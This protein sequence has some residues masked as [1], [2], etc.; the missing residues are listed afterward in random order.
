[1]H[2]RHEYRKEI[3]TLLGE[4]ILIADRAFL[5]GLSAQDASLDQFFETIRK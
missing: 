2:E 3:M 1:L 5:I 4:V